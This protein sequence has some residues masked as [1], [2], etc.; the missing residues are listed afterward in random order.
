ML[1]GSTEVGH[2]RGWSLVELVPSIRYSTDMRTYCCILSAAILASVKLL[3]CSASAAATTVQFVAADPFGACDNSFTTVNTTSGAVRGCAGG[4]WRKIG[5]GNGVPSVSALPAKC[6]QDDRRSNLV[7]LSAGAPGV[8]GCT[9]VNTWAPVGIPTV[10]A[11]NYPSLNAAVAAAGSNAEVVLPRGYIATLNSQLALTGANL[12]LRCETGSMIIKGF[13]GDL[14]QVTGANIAIDGCTIDGARIEYGGG[15]IA[16]S[17]AAGLLIK[18]STLENG[19]SAALTIYWASGVTVTGNKIVGN[20]GSPIFAQDFLDQ[21]EI[22]GNLADSSA[23][24]APDGVDT[25]GVHTYVAG[26][27]ATNISIHGNTI[28]HGGNNF[29]IEVG[30]FGPNSLPPSGVSISSN[31]ITLDLLSNGGISLSTLNN[32][33]V[34]SNTIDAQGYGMI[35][36]GIELAFT[37]GVS[38]T[39]NTVKNT[40]AGAAY[41]VSLDGSS[42]DTVSNNVFAGGIYIGTSRVQSPSVNGNVIQ[43]NVLTASPGAVLSRGLIWLQCNTTNCSVSRNSITANTLGGNGSGPGINFE[44]DYGSGVMDSNNAGGNQVT[45]ASI[46]ISIGPNVTNTIQ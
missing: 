30:A 24:I 19:A 17:N 27:T 5:G 2:S 33:R 7:Y 41:V 31:R 32:G 29:A 20:L 22:A 28:V 44:N 13:N 25:I 18:D 15:L 9:G 10:F 16:V 21:I 43:N 39:Y 8:Y 14:I 42:N 34:Q 4:V 26:G 40:V 46:V 6:A 11:T 3:N 12:T 38:A 23:V 1:T 37:N 45:G 35:I 36:T